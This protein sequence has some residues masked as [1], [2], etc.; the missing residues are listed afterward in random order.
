MSN[1]DRTSLGTIESSVPGARRSHLK[2]KLPP[3]STA[4][5][6]TLDQHIG[7]RIPGGQP[8]HSKQLRFDRPNRSKM[9]VLG[10]N[11]GTPDMRLHQQITARTPNTVALV[12]TPTPTTLAG[13]RNATR[14]TRKPANPAGRIPWA[15]TLVAWEKLPPEDDACY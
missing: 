9:A 5:Q 4:G 2:K 6:L 1:V 10:E 3:R 11:V 12:V 7:V 15:S 13:W 8:K 14:P